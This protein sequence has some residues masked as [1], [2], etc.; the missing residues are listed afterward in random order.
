MFF[1]TPPKSSCWG[2]A[3]RFKDPAKAK[4]AV[5]HFFNTYFDGM[6][7]EWDPTR[8]LDYDLTWKPSSLP[9]IE[10]PP[11]YLEPGVEHARKIIIFIT[12]A[13]LMFMQFLIPISIDDPES[14]NFLRRLVADAPVKL[15]PK[16]LHAY[17]SPGPKQTYK[18]RKE[19]YQKRIAEAL[20]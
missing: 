19:T 14:Y 3:L 12:P 9:K 1:Y 13:R 18:A 7:E 6:T 17:V 8:Q 11:E 20:A 4:Q 16:Y 10:W 5:N 2:H 15:K